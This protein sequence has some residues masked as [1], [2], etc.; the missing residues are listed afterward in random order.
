[1]YIRFNE[2]FVRRCCCCCCRWSYVEYRERV[3]REGHRRC[4]NVQ[5]IA[6][7]TGQVQ[8][9]SSSPASLVSICKKNELMA[10]ERERLCSTPKINIFREYIAKEKGKI[11]DKEIMEKINDC[12]EEIDKSSWSYTIH[13]ASRAEVSKIC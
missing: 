1:M 3:F 5:C 11:D 7:V 6:L 8:E 9:L 2:W 13:N 10:M 12:I 4:T